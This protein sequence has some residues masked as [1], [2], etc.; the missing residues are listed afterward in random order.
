MA[1]QTGANNNKNNNII[2]TIS[3]TITII[4]TIIIYRGPF[5]MGPEALFTKSKF[6]LLKKS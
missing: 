6:K 5:P 1:H 2:I 3:I 4:I